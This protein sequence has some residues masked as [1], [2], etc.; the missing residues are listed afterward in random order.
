MYGAKVYVTHAELLAHLATLH[1]IR[2]AR[3]LE[4]IG[5]IFVEGFEPIIDQD[6][7]LRFVHLIDK[8][9][10]QR[11]GLVATAPNG[12]EDLFAPEYRDKGYAKKYRRCRS[13]LHALLAETEEA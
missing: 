12:L 9:Y 8:M 10:D 13:R 4:S 6:Q 7:A 1:P 5:T 2:Y 11:V 3:M